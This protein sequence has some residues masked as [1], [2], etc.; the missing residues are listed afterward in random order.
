MNN[1]PA[2]LV[3][4]LRRF[5]QKGDDRQMLWAD[6]FTLTATDAIG[7]ASRLRCQVV[8]VELRAHIRRESTCRVHRTEDVRDRD[9][10]RAALG[11]VAAGGTADQRQ[12]IHLADDLLQGLLLRL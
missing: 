10:H 11:T 7:S 2:S 8:V 4:L 5:L 12:V 3:E 9:A 6:A 1:L